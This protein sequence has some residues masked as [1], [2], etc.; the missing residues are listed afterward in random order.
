MWLAVA[1]VFVGGIIVLNRY[2]RRREREGDWDKEG[3]G[4]PDHPEPGVKY[5]PLEA[6]PKPPFD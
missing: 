6:P 4:T 2:L 5:R 3:H 1:G